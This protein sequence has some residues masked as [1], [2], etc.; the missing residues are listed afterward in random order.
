MNIA[1]IVLTKRQAADVAALSHAAGNTD[2]PPTLREIQIKIS[3]TEVQ[4]GATNSKIVATR[5]G[6]IGEFGGKVQ[7]TGLFIIGARRFAKALRHAIR[8]RSRTTV[9]LTFGEGYIEVNGENI[10]VATHLKIESYDRISNLV[11]AYYTRTFNAAESADLPL[12]VFD[13]NLLSRLAKSAGERTHGALRQDHDRPSRWY[14]ITPEKDSWRFC[15]AI[16]ESRI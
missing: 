4:F 8:V 11:D 12:P 1:G 7:G 2:H 9:E 3:E 6:S 13:M 16:M 15:G 14:F 10:G 5:R